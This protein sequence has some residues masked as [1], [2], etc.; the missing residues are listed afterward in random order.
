M[1]RTFSEHSITM[2]FIMFSLLQ[3]VKTFWVEIYFYSCVVQLSAGCEE[4]RV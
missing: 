3:I 4:I 1:A 2:T